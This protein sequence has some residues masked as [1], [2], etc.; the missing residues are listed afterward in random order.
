MPPSKRMW[1]PSP[2][3]MTPTSTA[4][5]HTP[6][7][8]PRG[9]VQ[10]YGV[11]ILLETL[12]KDLE[13]GDV[14]LQQQR[15]DNGGSVSTYPI[16]VTK[17]EWVGGVFPYRLTLKDAETGHEQT[18]AWGGNSYIGLVAGPK[19]Q[20]VARQPDL[21]RPARPGAAPKWRGAAAT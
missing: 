19:V 17:P 14:L 2:P 18:V 9:A 3:P 16:V 7:L 1:L 21:V 12:V 15:K 4:P 8:T 13:P 10:T 11:R 5:A 20:A 6:A